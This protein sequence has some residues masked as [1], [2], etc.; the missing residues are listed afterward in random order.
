MGE[1]V[2][3]LALLDGVAVGEGGHHHVDLDEV[4][5]GRGVDRRGVAPLGHAGGGEAIVV[6]RAAV[7][8]DPG[9][10]GGLAI[11]VG[12]GADGDAGELAGGDGQ[13]LGGVDVAAGRRD[14]GVVVAGQGHGVG[15]DA[16]GL[17]GGGEVAEL[18]LG[19]GGAAHGGLDARGGVDG[20]LAAARRGQPCLEDEVGDVV[21]ERRQ[22]ACEVHE[23]RCHAR[24]IGPRV[25]L[26]ETDDACVVGDDG[27]QGGGEIRVGGVHGQRGVGRRGVARCQPR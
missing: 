21:A 19:L 26:A 16:G 10:M 13:H 14:G 3:G 22:R 23:R 15:A 6:E 17:D 2:P 8:R 12:D 9:A 5:R 24:S 27:A 11:A 18:G 7:Q 25:E 1:R 20:G 4:V